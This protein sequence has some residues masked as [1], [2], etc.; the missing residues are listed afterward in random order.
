MSSGGFLQV[1]DDADNSEVVLRGNFAIHST[2][3]IGIPISFFSASLFSIFSKNLNH[4][5]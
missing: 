1:V 5:N 2:Y 3:T 4:A